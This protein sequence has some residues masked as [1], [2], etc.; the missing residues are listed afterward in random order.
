MFIAKD[1]VCCFGTDLA[2]KKLLCEIL[3]LNWGMKIIPLKETD[4]IMYITGYEC[5]WRFI[6][7]EIIMPDDDC[8][9]PQQNSMRITRNSCA[10]KHPFHELRK[11]L[12]RGL[13]LC[14][15]DFRKSSLRVTDK[16][17]RKT[18]VSVTAF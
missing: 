16:N 10:Q 2:D 6:A 14:N 17:L 12:Q 11:E 7:N 3:G 4:E 8:P 5:C 1:R 18:E 13:G 9:P 15:I